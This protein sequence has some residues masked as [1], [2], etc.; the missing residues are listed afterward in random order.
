[1]F[2]EQR[3]ALVDALF[4]FE[5]EVL[6]IVRVRF[7]HP[8]LEVRAGITKHLHLAHVIRVMVHEHDAADV[9]QLVAEGFES[10]LES[11]AR[12]RSM[13]AAVDQCERIALDD[14]DLDR[15]DLPGCRQHDLVQARKSAYRRTDE[16]EGLGRH[17]A[18]ESNGGARAGSRLAVP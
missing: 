11:R 1:M 6:H 7:V 4:P 9:A 2:P 5:G 8:Q 13:N 3:V 17:A 14:V 12:V 16:T 18:P 10:R 15:A